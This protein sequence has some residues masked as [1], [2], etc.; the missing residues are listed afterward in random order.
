MCGGGS[1]DGAKF[2]VN[3]KVLTEDGVELEMRV[4]RDLKEFQ[5]AHFYYPR[6][7]LLGVSSA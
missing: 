7:R 1:S 4:P 3:T 5:V 2:E 6:N